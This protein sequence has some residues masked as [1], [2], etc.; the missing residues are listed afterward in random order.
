MVVGVTSASE[1]Q[2]SRPMLSVRADHMVL[3]LAIY[4]DQLLLGTPSD[5]VDVYDLATGHLRPPLFVESAS[6]DS[7]FAQTV[8]SLALSPNGTEL[9]VPTSDSLLRRFELGESLPADPNTLGA[10]T[11][12]V[13]AFAWAEVHFTMDANECLECH[14][15]ENATSKEDVPLPDSHFKAPVMGKGNPDDSIV[16]VVKDYEKNDDVYGARYNCNMCQTAQADK[17]NT[18][19]NG[20][21]SARKK[22]GR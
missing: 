14:H 8:R 20:F 12:A 13:G 15:P 5:R 3:D 21:V 17:V 16:W 7:G 18:P 1:A 22:M 6:A 4:R 9:A 10:A 11:D 19:N 2:A